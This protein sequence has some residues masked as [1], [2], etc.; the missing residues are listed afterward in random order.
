MKK[1]KVYH[2]YFVHC[3]HDLKGGLCYYGPFKKKKEAKKFKKPLRGF[4]Y[5]DVLYLPYVEFDGN[6][7]A[8]WGESGSFNTFNGV[9]YNAKIRGNIGDLGGQIEYIFTDITI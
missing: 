3:H 4:D 5:I 7:H 8:L 9:C 2:G 6:T 1:L